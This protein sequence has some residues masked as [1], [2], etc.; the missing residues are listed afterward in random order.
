MTID[1]GDFKRKGVGYNGVSPGPAL[2]FREGEDVV[3]NVTN[4]LEESTSIHWHGLILPYNMDGVPTVSFAGIEPGETFTYKFKTVQSGTYWYHSHSGFQEPDGAYGAIIIEPKV[5]EPFRY[6]RDYV[7]QLADPHPDSGARILRNLK[8]MPDYYNRQQQ[9]VGVFSRTSERTGS[10][11]P[12][13]SA[14]PGGK[15]G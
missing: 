2:R 6:D 1:T 14:W 10:R 11:Q 12:F 7:I 5:G 15:C 13:P 4:N 9:T 3:I 8:M